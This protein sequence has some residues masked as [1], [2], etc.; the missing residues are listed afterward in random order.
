MLITVTREDVLKQ[1]PHLAPERLELTD[2]EVA[3]RGVSVS[4]YAVTPGLPRAGHGRLT[5]CS[6]CGTY[7]RAGQ[8]HSALKPVAHQTL[9]M[10][11]VVEPADF[12][13]REER[14]AEER[15]ELKRRERGRY[16]G[17]TR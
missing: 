6:I 7:L 15:L 17:R 3:E 4:T 5:L 2:T 14:A 1:Y 8:P 12:E 10:L 16:Y 9:D 13:E 11:T